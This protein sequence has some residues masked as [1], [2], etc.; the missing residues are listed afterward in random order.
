MSQLSSWSVNGSTKSSA[1]CNRR[2]DLRAFISLIILALLVYFEMRGGRSYFDEAL[3]LVA[4]GYLLYAALLDRISRFDSVSLFILITVVLIGL[5][6]NVLSGIAVPWSSV[7]IDVI[8]ETKVL[9][10]YFAAKYYLSSG[11]IKHLVRMLSPVAKTYI[12]LS[13][14]FSLLS[15]VVNT[16]MTGSDRYGLNGFKFIFPFSFQFLAVT[17]IM[18]AVVMLD[19]KTKRKTTYYLMASISLIMATKSSPLIFGVLFLVLLAYFKKQDRLRMGTIVLLGALVLLL[20]TYQIQTYLLNENAPRYLFFYYGGVTADH[21]FP[22]GSGFA[23]FGSDQA[24]RNYSPLYFQ[25]G[26]S[27]LFGMTPED[28]SF[29]SDTFWPMA[30]GQFGWIGSLLYFYV[31]VRILLSFNGAASMESDA[32]AF[33]YAS[34]ASYVI[35]AVGSA[36]LSSSSGVI[37]FIAIALAQSGAIEMASRTEIENQGVSRQGCRNGCAKRSYQK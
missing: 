1:A 19:K 31:Y 28:G 2:I 25:Y 14:V 32:K 35:H 17:L 37:G 36:I 8:A 5:L 12:V 27:T 29:L 23:T 11:T 18:L 21:Y 15:Q 30:I 22:L 20:G 16:G 24:A 34:F 10:I 26:F 33:L 3:C 9:W 4:M 13:F 7:A 6:S